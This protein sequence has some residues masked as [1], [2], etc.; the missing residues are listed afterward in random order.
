MIQFAIRNIKVFFKDKMSVFFSLMSVFIVIGLYV[1][2]LGDVME[3]NLASLGDHK[4]F[5]MDS[6]I[7]AGLLSVTSITTTMGA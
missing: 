1:L 3:S 6:W 4:R 5:L 2:F 7:M